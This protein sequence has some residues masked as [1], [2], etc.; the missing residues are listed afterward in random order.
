MVSDALHS[1]AQTF[2]SAGIE[3]AE[4]DARTL[5]GHALRLDRVKL[6]A[7]SHRLLEARE[8]E[9]ISA[10]AARRLRHE[11][12]SR[13]LCLKGFCRLGAAVNPDSL[14]ARPWTGSSS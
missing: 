7:Q 2:R 14:A 4:A 10:L 6:I 5:I 12:A 9:T 3:N 8:I 13:I 11:P 1:I